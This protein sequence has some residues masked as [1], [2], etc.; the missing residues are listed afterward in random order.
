[1]GILRGTIKTGSGGLGTTLSKLF[2]GDT[3]NTV[4]SKVNKTKESAEF[5]YINSYEELLSELAAIK[6]EIT[7]IILHWSDTESNK[8]L[9]ANDIDDMQRAMGAE[10]I[11]YHYVIRR[12]GTLQRGRSPEE[13][14][15]HTQ[16]GNA[17]TLA[18]VMVGGYNCPTGTVN[19]AQ[20]QG[21]DSLTPAQYTTLETLL[22][23]YYTY[24]PGGQVLGHNDLEDVPD[25][26]FD[27]RS[28]CKSRFNRTSVY[29]GRVTN[30]LSVEEI[31]NSI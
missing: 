30:I 7:T 12:D 24:Y 6:R 25:P 13:Q 19:P 1:M 31:N 26:G 22:E 21:A 4:F 14:G 28:F 17:R 9:T 2:G 8:H 18:V 27:V 11:G 15:D 16:R 3:S 20:Y 23:V 29:A 10:K 5:S